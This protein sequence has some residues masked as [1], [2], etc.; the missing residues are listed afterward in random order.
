MYE[1]HVRRT[2]QGGTKLFFSMQEDPLELILGFLPY[3]EAQ[4]VSAVCREWNRASQRWIAN[5]MCRKGWTLRW[6]YDN[7]E[8]SLED[9]LGL[10]SQGCPHYVSD[11]ERKE[12]V[13]V[14]D[15]ALSGIP[16]TR[17]RKWKLL[18]TRPSCGVEM[19]APGLSQIL[20]RTFCIPWEHNAP[21]VAA[22]EYVRIVMDGESSAPS[23]VYMI[24]ESNFST[25]KRV[26]GCLPRMAESIFSW[27]SFSFHH[28][29][30]LYLH[31]RTVQAVYSMLHIPVLLGCRDHI[32]TYVTG[33]LHFFG[34]A[35]RLA[36][37][38]HASAA[39]LGFYRT[40]GRRIFGPAF[41][42]RV[43]ILFCTLPSNAY[44]CTALA[45]FERYELLMSLLQLA[46][47]QKKSYISRDMFQS[48]ERALHR[49]Q[50]LPLSRDA[51]PLLCRKSNALVA[52]MHRLRRRLQE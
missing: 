48:M 40:V 19:R 52:E 43:C 50:R 28:P 4:R 21:I 38:L 20:S 9:L 17:A 30:I 37:N 8:A 11:Q 34:S 46:I 3:R 7:V 29:S 35:H 32:S 47:L 45:C 24:P 42:R 5:N 39:M 44:F 51:P 23:V 26:L 14:L 6:H 2:K 33:M 10:L 1:T 13:K 36:H 22:H 27:M 41:A 18:N 49:A 16:R 31:G 25:R 15:A 12:M